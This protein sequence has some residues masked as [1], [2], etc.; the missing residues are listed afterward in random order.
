MVLTQAGHLVVHS[1]MY[2]APQN[3]YISA[4]DSDDHRALIVTDLTDAACDASNILVELTY[5]NDADINNAKWITFQDSG[6][7]IG[8]ISG[9][10]S[11]T[12]FATSSDYRLKTDL[13][14]IEDATGTINKL[15][16][17]DFAWLRNTDKR[18]MGVL[19]HEAQAVVPSAITGE[20][21]AMTTKQYQ[22]E[23]GKP[24]SKEVIAPQGADY[25]KFVPLLL[26]SIQE[27]SAKVAALENK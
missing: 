26:K 15:K 12:T 6:G 3:V 21:D 5:N 24:Q 7:E 18:A 27:L 1:S 14:D 19:A 22:G 2:D 23:D 13:K 10:G 25:S 20:K 11:T 8:S 4:D 9:S 17:Y 16:L